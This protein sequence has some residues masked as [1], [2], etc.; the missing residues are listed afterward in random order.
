[1]QN[2]R[3]KA[4]FKKRIENGDS[5]KRAHLSHTNL[6]CRE[7]NV[8]RGTEVLSR[9]SAFGLH[10]Q[11]IVHNSRS[12]SQKC[13]GK[14]V[15]QGSKCTGPAQINT[16]SDSKT[17]CC[18]TYAGRR[19]IPGLVPHVRIRRVSLL[20]PQGQQL[21]QQ[22]SKQST[23]PNAQRKVYLDLQWNKSSLN[24]TKKSKLGYA[25]NIDI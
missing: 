25:S 21:L 5:W 15:G 19:H 2:P 11:S 1:M 23:R 12:H 16:L 6:G 4:F 9:P 8:N 7:V 24:C 10:W 18:L 22:Q 14:H 3:N 17:N 13:S 20:L